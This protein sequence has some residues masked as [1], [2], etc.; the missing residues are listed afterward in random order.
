MSSYRTDHRINASLL[1]CYIG[2]DFDPIQAVTDAREGIEE[3][4]A[5]SVG[6]GLHEIMEVGIDN[7]KFEAIERL[8]KTKGPKENAIQLAKDM[9]N[10]IF[11]QAPDYILDMMINGK[12]E[13]EFYTTEFKALLDLVHGGVGADY[14]TTSAATLADFKRDFFKYGL[15]IQ[16]HHYR[17]VAELEQFY[18]I[19]VSKAKGHP[20][21]IVTS[22]ETCLEYGRQEWNLA[23]S[24]HKEFQDLVLPTKARECVISAPPWAVLEES[25]VFEVEF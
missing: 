25:P 9:A 10:A 20:V 13:Q 23:Y 18:F 24:R 7:A 1:K 8:Y 17:K 14:K 3:T 4:Q 5:M 22:D 19:V 6:T 11:D 16:E 2:R 12:K 15:H 21:W